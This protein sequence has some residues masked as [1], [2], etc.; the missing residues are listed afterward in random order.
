MATSVNINGKKVTRPGVYAVTESGIKNPSSNLPHGNICIIDD[1]IG[2]SWGGGSGVNGALKSGVDAVYEST[3]IQ[4]FRDFV[5]GGEL[6]NLGKPLFKP[7]GNLPGVNKVYIVRAA[8]TTAATISVVFTGGYTLSIKPYDEGLVANGTLTSGVLTHG[9]AAKVA[10]SLVDATKFRL[11]F[12]RGSYS[13]LDTTN[14]LPYDGIALSEATAKLLLSSPEVTSVTELIEWMRN[15]NNFKT[16]F[17]LAS[18][19]TGAT[20][21]IVIAD[22]TGNYIL[23]TGGTEA[24]GAADFTAAIEAV[25]DLDNTFFLATAFGVTNAIGLN[26][27]KIFDFIVNDSRYSKFMVVAG[28]SDKEGFSGASDSSEAVAAY[29]NSDKVIVVHGGCKLASRRGFLIQSQ[30]YKAAVVLGRICGLAPQTPVTLKSID[31]DGEVH[32]LTDLEKEYALAKGILTTH[33]D[34]ELGYYV[35]QQGI[36]SLQNNEFLVNDNGT[37]FDIAVKRIEAALNKEIVINAKRTFFGK[38]MDGPNRNTVTEQDVKLW[39]N[40]FLKSRTASSL[41]DNLIV[42]YDNIEVEVKGDN[43]FITYDF[44]PNYSISKIIATGIILEK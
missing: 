13:G 19:T 34:G 12:Y 44:V 28:G 32:K 22:V 3:T 20:A 31:I 2:A 9:Y 33:Y 11:D 42:R 25:K 26:N 21:P 43:Y 17:D 39:L 7:S 29:Y 1:G 14:N 16:I 40:G 6:W 41:Q 36:N 23:A 27:T 18:V 8:T 35:V 30:L 37:S 38:P 24:Y 4:Q 10:Q 5:K 15:S